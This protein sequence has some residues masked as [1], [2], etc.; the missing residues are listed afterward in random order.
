MLRS[1]IAAGGCVV[2]LSLTLHEAPNVGVL[3]AAASVLL[4]AGSMCVLAY[5]VSHEVT[6]GNLPAVVPLRTRD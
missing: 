3:A 1:M 6:G 2:E 5:R 4:A